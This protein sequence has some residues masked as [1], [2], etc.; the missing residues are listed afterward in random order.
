MTVVETKGGVARALFS[1][2]AAATIAAIAGQFFLAGMA[3]FGAGEGWERHG[4]LGGAI[5]LPILA[6]L[7]MA[8]FWGRLRIYRRHT[9]LLAASYV[10]QV[11]LVAIGQAMEL[12]LLAALHPVNGVLMAVL[13]LSLALRCHR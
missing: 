9:A 10:T 4:A 2:L 3:V 11:L 8:F 13:A 5:A 7:A 12:P 1:A 6:L